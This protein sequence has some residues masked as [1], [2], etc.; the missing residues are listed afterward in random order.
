MRPKH[1]ILAIPVP[2]VTDLFWKI[3]HDGN[4]QA[5]IFPG[6]SH[7]R[8]SCLRLDI[9][10][11][12]NGHPPPCQ[13]LGR[14]IVQ[15]VEGVVGRRLIVL[16]VTHQPTAVIGGEHFAR[17]KMLTCKRALPRPAGADEYDEGELGD[18]EF[19]GVCKASLSGERGM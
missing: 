12:N 16:I 10:G 9:R 8:G 4:G 2:F 13:P 11:I 7:Q 3:Q 18:G 1:P 15:N 6:E 19:H 14:N 17:Q 5:V